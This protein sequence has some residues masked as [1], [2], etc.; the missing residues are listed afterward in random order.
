MEHIGSFDKNGRYVLASESVKDKTNNYKCIGCSKEMILCKGSIIKPYFRHKID[1][2]CE[3][4]IHK[5]AKYRL[6][7]LLNDKKDI[8]IITSCNRCNSEI[9]DRIKHNVNDK[10]MVEYR[11]DDVHFADVCTLNESSIKCIYEIIVSHKTDSRP[12][13]WYE[14]KGS[15]IL[16]SISV[17]NTSIIHS[18]HCTR[19]RICQ[20]CIEKTQLK[21]NTQIDTEKYDKYTKNFEN[22]RKNI[23]NSKSRRPCNE[24]GD[25]FNMDDMVE[26]DNPN[27]EKYERNGEYKYNYICSNCIDVCDVCD[28]YITKH[29]KERYKYCYDCNNITRKCDVCNKIVQGQRDHACDYVFL[30]E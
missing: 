10:T 20:T 18:F 11:Y 16:D 19:N 15:E 6:W 8:N 17:E 30:E 9:I 2:V 25:W 5:H 22:N 26:M 27:W 23:I 3:T 4:D 1:N 29:D 24:C 12:E 7:Q 14:I 28:E 13:P 21:T